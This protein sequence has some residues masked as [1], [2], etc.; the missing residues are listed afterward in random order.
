VLGRP[1]ERLAGQRASFV[2]VSALCEGK[3]IWF[4]LTKPLTGNTPNG[5]VRDVGD[6]GDVRDV[7]MRIPS[8]DQTI[9]TRAIALLAG[10][11]HASIDV[12]GAAGSVH[13]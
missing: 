12:H 3:E 7:D 8:E 9:G 13:S 6:T 4:Y 5:T 11:Q 2:A 1:E 10:E